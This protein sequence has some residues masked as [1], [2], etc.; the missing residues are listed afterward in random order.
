MER[1]TLIDNISV[2]GNYNELYITTVCSN[3][4]FIYLISEGKNRL[5]YIDN[6]QITVK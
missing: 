3:C 1:L 2:R 6:K 5:A 4:P